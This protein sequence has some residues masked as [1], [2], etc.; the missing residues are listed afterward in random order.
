MTARQPVPPEQCPD[1]ETHGNPF[2]YCPYC[3]WTETP[4][5]S[6][7][8]AKA[9]FDQSV[10]ARAAYEQGHKDG[11]A[12]EQARIRDRAIAMYGHNRGPRWFAQLLGPVQ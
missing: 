5:E 6:E 12:A 8:D 2:R 11:V 10:Q 7:P 1:P 9:K 3:T 4:G